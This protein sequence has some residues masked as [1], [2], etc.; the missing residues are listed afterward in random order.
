[1]KKKPKRKFALKSLLPLYDSTISDLM[2]EEKEIG[3]FKDRPRPS[4]PPI[5]DKRDERI[6]VKFTI[7]HPFDSL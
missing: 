5:Y 7:K 2:K 1:M 3:S 6:I 4:R